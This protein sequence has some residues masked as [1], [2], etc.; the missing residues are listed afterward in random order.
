M[1]YIVG[2]IHGMADKLRGLVQIIEPHLTDDDTIVFIGDYIDRGPSPYEVVEFL[3]RLADTYN[4]VF[5]KGN[6]EDLFLRYVSGRDPDGVYLFN[7]GS[8]TIQSYRAHGGVHRLPARHEE[9]FNRLRMYHEGS[10]YIAVH[11]GLNPDTAR[12]AEQTEHDM[13]WIREAFYRSSY[14]WPATVVFGHT[15][16]MQL[17]GS[18]EVYVNDEINIIGI[19]TGAVYGGPLTCLRMPDRII[20][21]S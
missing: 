16:T 3:V 11:A 17:T 9:F 13:L 21:Q 10:G 5:L 18:Q 20:F 12:L 15:P 7:G 19:D 1:D 14:R 4:V 2:D 6:H 8:Y